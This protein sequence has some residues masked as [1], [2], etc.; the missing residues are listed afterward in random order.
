MARPREFDTTEVL[1]RAL[2]VFW[3]KGFDGS[4]IEDLTTATGLSRASLYGAFTDKEGLFKAAVESYQLAYAQ[5]VPPLT[6]EKS[7]LKWIAEL[8]QVAVTRA[9][10]GP[11]GCFVQLSLGQCDG[12]RAD[13]LAMLRS[14]A[15]TTREQ[16]RFALTQAVAKH[17]LTSATPID[18]VAN[19]FVVVL[20]GIAADA[21]AGQTLD[22]LQPVVTEAL[23]LL[24]RYQPQP[25]PR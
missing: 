4:S 8:M 17:E 22:H 16:L 15:C 13:A 23:T 11:T 19:Y 18:V 20:A 3:R 6:A 12:R 7:P 2:D 9:C 24:E 25:L 21:R 1:T 5:S 14:S 10:E